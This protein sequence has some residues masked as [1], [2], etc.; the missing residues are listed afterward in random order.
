[1]VGDHANNQDDD[2]TAFQ[3][4]AIAAAVLLFFGWLYWWLNYGWGGS[5]DAIAVPP[6][7]QLDKWQATA[8][9]DHTRM[10]TSA[11]VNAAGQVDAVEP[12]SPQ[13]VSA[14][15]QPVVRAQADTAKPLPSANQPPSSAAPVP[16]SAQT[17]IQTQIVVPTPSATANVEA[18]SSSVTQMPIGLPS[19]PSQATTP[20]M[21]EGVAAQLITHTFP[22]GTQVTVGDSGFEGAFRQAINKRDTAQALVFDNLQFEPGSHAISSSSDRQLRA[23]A[24]L[25]Q[26]HPEVK[27]LIRGHT[28][29]TGTPAGNAQLSLLRANEVGVALV[30]L[31]VDRRRLRIMGMGDTVPLAS[32]GTEQGRQ[33]NRRVDLMILP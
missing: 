15:Q 11:A 21:V 12:V 30:R 9:T 19:P 7:S 5:R 13:P 32:N 18:Q 8:T 2:L 25:L 6:P 10:G 14:L 3:E 33:Q 23:T 1:M 4:Y 17:S 29:E 24:A 31:G 22:D 20:A 28:D 16:P 27:V 26:M